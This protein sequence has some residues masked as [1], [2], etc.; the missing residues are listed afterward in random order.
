MIQT[1]L[2][3]VIPLSVPCKKKGNYK[4]QL[5]RKNPE[6]AGRRQRRKKSGFQACKSGAGNHEFL[7]NGFRK[8]MAFRSE[9]TNHAITSV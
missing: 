4:K 9:V 1:C 2:Y 5:L 7:A 6:N 8:P 3:A